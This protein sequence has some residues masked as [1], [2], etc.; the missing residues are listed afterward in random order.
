MRCVKRFDWLEIAFI[1]CGFIK[2]RMENG[3]MWYTSMCIP[4]WWVKVAMGRRK[5]ATKK[6]QTRKKQVVATVFKCPF[7]SHDDAV[8]CKLCVYRTYGVI[9]LQLIARIYVGIVTVILATYPVECA[10]SLFKPPYTV[11][12]AISPVTTTH[13]VV[14][15]RFKRSYWRVY[16]LDR[17]V[18]SDAS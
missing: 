13:I 6:I 17:W 18:R 3:F 15:N 10:Q 7:C 12:N 16:R 8:E 1:W 9:W 2:S 5:K 11:C 4:D 14:V